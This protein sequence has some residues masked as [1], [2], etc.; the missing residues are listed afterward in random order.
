V[1]FSNN[2]PGKMILCSS[3]V[4][5]EFVISL[6]SDILLDSGALLQLKFNLCIPS[7]VLKTLK[8]S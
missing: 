8:P 6:N 2:G 7:T 4:L 5:L 3:I 1:L